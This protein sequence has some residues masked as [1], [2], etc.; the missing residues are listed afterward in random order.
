MKKLLLFSVIFCLFHLKTEAQTEKGQWMVGTQIGDFSYR[1]NSTSTS[2]SFTMDI[3]PSAGYFV[4]KNLALGLSIPV[5]TSTTRATDLV[6]KE[7]EFGIAPF[8]QYYFGNGKLKPYVSLQY[9][10]S[11]ERTY[12]NTNYPGFENFETIARKNTWSPGIGVAYFITKTIAVNTIINYNSSVS[13]TDNGRYTDKNATL[14]L[15]FNLFFGKT[16]QQ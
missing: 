4:S 6:Y 16:D 10:L 9:K 2:H 15:G 5:I 7:R 12:R 11:R 8:A 13:V 3:A 1:K 14:H